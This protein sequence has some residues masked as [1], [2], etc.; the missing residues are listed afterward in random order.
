MSDGSIVP[1]PV[2]ENTTSS[3][4]VLNFMD[5]FRLLSLLSDEKKESLS[6]QIAFNG[7]SSYLMD[8]DQLPGTPLKR[9]TRI[10]CPE[11]PRRHKKR[12]IRS[13]GVSSEGRAAALSKEFLNIIS[14]R[15]DSSDAARL[16]QLGSADYL[17][18]F[19][20]AIHQQ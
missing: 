12:C 1:E 11:A 3:A 19:H 20:A 17:A 2:R 4:I 14:S 16:P 6:L 7:Q 8:N 9:R 13:P 18:H 5:S 15:E 10:T